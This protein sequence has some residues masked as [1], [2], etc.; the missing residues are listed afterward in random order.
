MLHSIGSA[1]R[2]KTTSSFFSCD[3]P[4]RRLGKLLVDQAR[5]LKAGFYRIDVSSIGDAQTRRL[6][7]LLIEQGA[8]LKA[9]PQK[10][11]DPFSAC[12]A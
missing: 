11:F 4:T 7:N 8:H 3:A 10:L 9:Y 5:Y 6:G 2:A 12:E 1:A